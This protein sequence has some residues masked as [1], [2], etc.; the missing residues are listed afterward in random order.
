MKNIRLI[1]WTLLYIAF[2]LTIRSG[3]AFTVADIGRVN[4]PSIHTTYFMTPNNQSF[5]VLAT[6]YVGEYL[7]GTCVYS[8]QYDIGKS[9]VQ[10]GDYVDFDANKLKSLVGSGYSCMTVYYY[11][12]QPV[13]DTVKLVWDG[14]NYRT[15]IPVT[16]TV[17]VL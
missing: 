15:T 12:T 11:Y 9:Y 6:L 3:H 13:V 4:G 1:R 16:S 5:D 7:N 14:F 2:V 10:T 8:G 17:T